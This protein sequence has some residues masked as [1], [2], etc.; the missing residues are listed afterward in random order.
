MDKKE[1]LKHGIQLLADEIGLLR[2]YQDAARRQGDMEELK[3]LEAETLRVLYCKAALHEKL[4]EE[5]LRTESP[6]SR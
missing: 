1:A 5:G 3:L 4:R 6:V 2:G